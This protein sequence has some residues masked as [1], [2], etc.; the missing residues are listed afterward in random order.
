[1]YIIDY[2]YKT[3]NFDDSELQ[4]RLYAEIYYDSDIK[5]ESRTT[6]A[7]MMIQFD[8]MTTETNIE[9]E[10]PQRK[11]EEQSSASKTTAGKSSKIKKSKISMKCIIRILKKKNYCREPLTYNNMY[12]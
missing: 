6:N 9:S 4:A 12:I 1:M 10:K 7:P 11:L 2:Y 8:N 3:D 5:D